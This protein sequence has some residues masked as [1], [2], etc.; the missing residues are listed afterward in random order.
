MQSNLD[1]EETR[2]LRQYFTD[3][4]Q[5]AVR[6]I[7]Q[8]TII[9]ITFLYF[10]LVIQ[11]I[12]LIVISIAVFLNPSVAD[13]CIYLYILIITLLRHSSVYYCGTVCS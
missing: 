6:L 1:V 11:S 9:I 4:L 8:K 10:C 12:I 3:C 7:E 13:D 2:V 5:R